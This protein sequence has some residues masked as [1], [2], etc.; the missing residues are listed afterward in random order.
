MCKLVLTVTLLTCVGCAVTSGPNRGE[1]LRQEFKTKEEQ[2]IT[3][4]AADRADKA[5][6]RTSG[7]TASATAAYWLGLKTALRPHPIDPASVARE[8]DHLPTLSVDPLL[9]REGQ[10]V[11]EKMRA[12]GTSIKA[13]SAFEIIFHFPRSRFIEAET[14]SRDAIAQCRLVERMRPD[15]TIRYGIEFSPFDLPTP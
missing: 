7:P 13:I 5:A 4:I 12:A 6:G 11:A 1:E 3:D 9:V 10:V 15:L 2:S 14:R 8:I